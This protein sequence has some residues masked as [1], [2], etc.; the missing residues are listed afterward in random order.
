MLGRKV[1]EVVAP[2]VAEAH[3]QHLRES[4][5]AMALP[6]TSLTMRRRGNGS[7]DVDIRLADAVAGRLMTSLEVYAAPRRGRLG[8]D[9]EPTIRRR[10]AYFLNCLILLGRGCSARCW[11]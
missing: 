8:G 11:V 6:A 10:A 4:E 1:S 2:G 9:D 3:E 5:Q 7:T